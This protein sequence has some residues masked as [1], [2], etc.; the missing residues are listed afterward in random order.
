MSSTQSV[1]CEGCGK[2]HT[3]EDF[4]A[5]QL[6]DPR[7]YKLS[8]ENSREGSALFLFSPLKNTLPG[9]TTAS[10]AV[11]VLKC[12]HAVC[13]PCAESQRTF[14]PKVHKLGVFVCYACGVRYKFDVFHKKY[15]RT[16]ASVLSDSEFLGDFQERIF[17]GER[18]LDFCEE[19]LDQSQKMM[20]Q[21]H[22][23]SS[24]DYGANQLLSREHLAALRKF[25]NSF[26]GR[27]TTNH[28]LKI[29]ISFASSR[30]H[31]IIEASDDGPSRPQE[32]IH[33]ANRDQLHKLSD[34]KC[35][36]DVKIPPFYSN[37]EDFDSL[38]DLVRSNP[39]SPVNYP[40]RSCLSSRREH[41]AEGTTADLPLSARNPNHEQTQLER[42]GS[43][44]T[45]RR[46]VGK[47]DIEDFP[48]VDDR[49]VPQ[50]KAPTSDRFQPVYNQPLQ[51]SNQAQRMTERNIPDVKDSD[52]THTDWPQGVSQQNKH[53]SKSIMPTIFSLNSNE[54]APS[55]TF[56]INGELRLEICMK[57]LEKLIK[58]EQNHTSLFSS[59]SRNEASNPTQIQS[60]QA[61]SNRT[62][63][64]APSTPLQ[65]SNQQ[66]SGVAVS[67]SSFE[68]STSPLLKDETRKIQLESDSNLVPKKELFL[69][70]ASQAQNPR[71]G[72]QSSE[73]VLA[74]KDLTEYK[75][76]MSS[77]VVPAQ[78]SI[79][80]AYLETRY[81][82]R[83]R[84]S[85]GHSTNQKNG[86]K[87]PIPN[88]HPPEFKYINRFK[89]LVLNRKTEIG[90]KSQLGVSSN[91]KDTA[92]NSWQRSSQHSKAP[93]TSLV[94]SSAHF[95]T[96]S[97]RSEMDTDN[98]DGLV[99]ETDPSNLPLSEKFSKLFEKPRYNLHLQH[100]R[101]SL[102]CKEHSFHNQSQTQEFSQSR[103]RGDASHTSLGLIAQKI[104]SHS[105]VIE[106]YHR[107]KANASPIVTTASGSGL[108]SSFSQ[109][110]PAYVASYKVPPAQVHNSSTGLQV[111]NMI[112]S[113][114]RSRSNPHSGYLDMF[115]SARP[116][117]RTN[118]RGVKSINSSNDNSQSYVPRSLITPTAAALVSKLVSPLSKQMYTSPVG[119]V[120]QS[121]KGW[122]KTEVYSYLNA[123]KSPENYVSLGLSQ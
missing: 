44:K 95:Q 79:S 32:S 111:R 30:C 103:Q 45:I 59:A 4:V 26:L 122:K 102:A 65:H 80:P 35:L 17:G 85:H 3:T 62:A 123:S 89:T 113:T 81:D 16:N 108:M 11:A 106:E 73:N 29:P 63:F 20:K 76:L 83:A 15:L 98:L 22:N 8:R 57:S 107:R 21:D 92:S 34:P 99:G 119:S 14:I 10:V 101:G 117:P 86:P 39:S 58:G 37:R 13:A 54:K 24:E 27:P 48:E 40:Q 118:S 49:S 2:S 1:V 41:R 109:K 28:D 74:L 31:S 100:S 56:T 38:G 19:K 6:D 75:H 51:N 84:A 70:N 64:Q 60:N 87:I 69:L 115:R 77:D 97:R 55:D 105:K 23:G 90:D 47:I 120:P 112:A 116:S 78:R 68:E 72:S 42:E 94:N 93:T 71:R 82:K 66:A 110:P 18:S 9:D 67:T 25:P 96:S 91:Q 43:E 104:D 36:L 12:G 121:T 88:Y 46:R 5:S 61:K 53:P 114:A 52:V 7:K 50:A 33:S